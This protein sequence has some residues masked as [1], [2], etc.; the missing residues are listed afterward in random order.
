MKKV[1]GVIPARWASTRFPGKPLALIAGR[2]L[3]AHVIERAS[4]AERLDVV[5]VATD[6]DRIRKTVEALGV[7]VVMTRAEH[8]SG[9]DRVA[10]AVQA[11]GAHVVVNIQGDEPLLDPALV[12][13]LAAILVNEPEWDMATAATPI[14][15]AAEIANPN[16]VKVVWGRSHQALYFSR[17]PIPFVR[18]GDPGDTGGVYWRHVGVYAYQRSFLERM[19]AANPARLEQLEKLE[20]LRALAMGGR[21]VVVET[22]ERAIGVDTRADVKYVEE[23]MK[24]GSV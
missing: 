18:D 19:V 5:I 15:N 6:D 4:L 14:E 10:E 24:A 16:V 20:Q 13:Q 1:A 2:P 9:T 11:T 8:P 22:D 17:S 7:R 23:L 12:D 21:I 3:I